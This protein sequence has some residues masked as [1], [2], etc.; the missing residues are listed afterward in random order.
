MIFENEV[1]TFSYEGI[2]KITPEIVQ[3][4]LDGQ[5]DKQGNE[6]L[7]EEFLT[8]PKI[9]SKEDVQALLAFFCTTILR[10][11]YE[12]E[13]LKEIKSIFW[14]VMKQKG[15]D[16]KEFRS[17]SKEKRKLENIVTADERESVILAFSQGKEMSYFLDVNTSFAYYWNIEEVI[18]EIKGALLKESVE[19]IRA[20]SDKEQRNKLKKKL[21][22]LCV[23]GIMPQRDGRKLVKYGRYMCLDFDGFETVEETEKIKEKLEKDPYTLLAFISPSGKGLKVFIEVKTRITQT[24]HLELFEGAKKHFSYIDGWDDSVKDISRACYL[25]YDPELYYNPEAKVFTEKV[26]LIKTKGNETYEGTS[27]GVPSTSSVLPYEKATSTDNVSTLFHQRDKNIT[28]AQLYKT[29]NE[30]YSL[31]EG[32]RNTNLFKL[33]KS[34]FCAGVSE[35]EI[36]EFFNGE[37]GDIFGDGFEEM[38]GIVD[39]VVSKEEDFNTKPWIDLPFKNIVENS[40]RNSNDFDKSIQIVIDKGLEMDEDAIRKE[41]S[42]I[43]N[44][45][46][47]YQAFWI[48]V[49]DDKGNFK[50][51]E[52]DEEKFLEFLQ[53][54]GVFR[55]ESGKDISY[56]QI[57][58]N[59]IY[60]KTIS[61]VKN[62]VDKHLLQNFS[63]DKALLNFFLKKNESNAYNKLFLS[64]L[65][66]ESIEIYRDSKDEVFKFFSDRILKITADEM[67]LISYNELEKPVFH[68]QIE[69]RKVWLDSILKSDFEKFIENVSGEENLKSFMSAIG[70]LCSSYKSQSSALAVIL[71]DPS[72]SYGSA[73]GGKGKSLIAKAISL[74][75]YMVR[76][77]GKKFNPD[78]QFSLAPVKEGTTVLLIDDI[79]ENFSFKNFYNVITEDLEVTRKHKDKVIIPFKKSPKVLL[80][81][82]YIL[83]GS[84]TSSKRRR[85]D[86]EL[87]DYYNEHKTP[88][89][90]F[91]KEFF[92]DWNEQEW[93]AFY[94]FMAR[95]VQTYLK[96]G[97]IKMD[98]QGKLEYKVLVSDT[99]EDFLHFMEEH[100]EEFFTQ[101]SLESI[102]KKYSNYST[103]LMPSKRM[104][105]WLTQWCKFYGYSLEGKRVNNRRWYYLRKN[106]LHIPASTDYQEAV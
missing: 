57:E 28:I 32:R 49:T 69:K 29:W 86:L 27:K 38:T 64:S 60:P 73:E 82:N 88:L 33:G 52:T 71:N 42:Q 63:D 50:R 37:I 34:L 44:E 102:S 19:L 67:S 94:M 48:R 45:V 91:G 25:S 59:V 15:K 26:K 54:K 75:S 5:V 6:A 12:D 41:L 55:I 103:K 85:W 13:R 79:K 18:K 95:C 9:S 81:T 66:R 90:E 62:I 51:Y 65:N 105:T 14:N 35:N 3:Q 93:N 74:F 77:D 1:N 97:I 20:E 58:D 16:S 2:E 56:Y 101:F 39:S 104:K 96:E 70:Y 87:A 30:K 43:K 46:D 7:L 99:S 92:N 17:L 53:A 31:E 24:D 10:T 11:K 8:D 68:S 23:N 40:L 98:N 100:K 21:P 83:R 61:G 80:A 4:M 78:D 47:T 106:S 89:K 76:L 72:S 84:D 22:M 36:R